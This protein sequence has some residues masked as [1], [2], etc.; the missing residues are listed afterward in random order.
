MAVEATLPEIATIFATAA[1][2]SINPCAIGVL[3]L[4]IS[5]MISSGEKNKLLIRGLT[6]IFAVFITYLLA[7]LGLIFVFASMPIVLAEYISIFV[8]SLIV[9]LG[10]IE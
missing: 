1:V 10:L 9:L 2:D 4:L 5:V 8:G 7:G 3:I 6:Y